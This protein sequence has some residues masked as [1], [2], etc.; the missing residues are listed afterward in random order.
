M[1][2]KQTTFEGH[3]INYLEAGSGFPI[4][5]IHGVGPGTS[6]NA[7]YG[8]VL[9]P[10]S[11]RF[12]IFGMDMIGFGGSDRNRNQPLF[13]VELWVRQAEAMLALMPAGP[14]GIIGH[15]MGGAIALKVASRNERIVKAM[16]SCSVGVSY[17]IND[18]LNGFW[19]MPADRAAMKQIMGRM[20]YSA[21][22]I[23]DQMIEDRWTLLTQA[24]YPEYFGELF[25]EPRQRL[26]DAAILS[27]DEIA[28]IKAKVVMLHGR[29]DQPCPPEQTTLIL[30]RKLPRADI[31]L[32]GRCGHNLPRERSTDFV[33]Q[34][35][36][37]FGSV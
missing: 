17:P 19:S 14:L 7:N 20:M 30:A 4:L 9:E 32:L 24:G 13:D 29:D 25:A 15:S 34:A 22:N 2:N 27:D 11:E 28:R 12:H 36:S 26:L 23:S 31:H 37:L 5:M 33:A 35:Y 8:P 21:E 3:N 6:I 18:A 16:T 10:L 1:Q